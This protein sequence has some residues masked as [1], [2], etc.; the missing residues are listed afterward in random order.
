MQIQVAFRIDEEL[1][2]KFREKL[3]RESKVG[4]LFF[5]NAVK[6]YLKKDKKD[7]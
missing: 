5:E 4:T 1:Y 6:E 7:E 3:R 2:K